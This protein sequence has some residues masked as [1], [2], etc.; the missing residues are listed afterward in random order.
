M[1]VLNVMGLQL[2]WLITR[3]I[4]YMLKETCRWGLPKCTH[5]WHYITFW[6][7][8]NWNEKL[9][10]WKGTCF[11]SLEMF[12][13]SW[14]WIWL[15]VKKKFSQ[16]RAEVLSVSL[17]RY[18]SLLNLDLSFPVFGRSIHNI[19]TLFKITVSLYRSK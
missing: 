13:T 8:V 7:A 15:F 16:C 17:K 11:S 12:K 1:F 18:L 3:I 9:F 10:C 4:W 14:I 5:L 2:G 19:F 6:R